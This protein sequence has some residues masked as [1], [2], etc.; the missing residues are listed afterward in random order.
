VGE[1]SIELNNEQK[2]AVEATDK[3]LIVLAGPGSGK[4]R[5][6]IHKLNYIIAKLGVAPENILALTFTNKA[7]SEIRERFEKAANPFTSNKVW[8]S[9]FHSLALNILRSN[10][11]ASGLNENFTL[12]DSGDSKKVIKNLTIRMG[13]DYDKHELKD[14][15]GAISNYKN[16]NYEFDTDEEVIYQ[17]Y[18]RKLKE[19]NSIDFDDILLICLEMLSKEKAIL[20][21]YRAKFQ[22]LLIDEFQ[23]TNYIQHAIVD[24][25]LGYNTQTVLVGDV[26]QSIY[27]WR[28][29]NPEQLKVLMPKARVIRLIGNYRSKSNI[30]NLC[31]KLIQNNY[32]SGREDM[33]SVSGDNGEAVEYHKFIESK[34]ECTVMVDLLNRTTGSKAILIRVNSMSR[35]L[36]EALNLKAIPYTIVGG[37]RF[38]E[39][40]EI[41]DALA[42]IKFAL[43]PFDLLSFERIINTPKRKLGAKTVEKILG[44]SQT[45]SMNL[46]DASTALISKNPEGYNFC[47]G[48]LKLRVLIKDDL[49]KALKYVYNDMGL[50]SYYKKIDEETKS[51]HVEN[52]DSLLNAVREYTTKSS[53]SID[54]IIQEFDD[55]E[56]FALKFIENATLNSVKESS[57]INGIEIMTVHMAKGKEFDTVWVPGLEDSIYPHYLP[58]ESPDEEEER[59]LLF[60][61]CSRAKE[62]LYLSSSYSR[63]KYGEYASN[64]ESP[65]IKE[66][67]NCYTVFDQGQHFGAE[68]WSRPAQKYINLLNHKTL[69]QSE[70]D[71][72]VLGDTLTHQSFG[73]GVV[74]EIDGSTLTIKFSSGPKIINAL[75]APLQI[76]D[77]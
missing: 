8:I 6:I 33:S 76:A 39:R 4:T 1:V 34:D 7:A 35:E 18:Q 36:E 71:N 17:A 16:G 72:L 22:Y 55:G 29:A 28:N 57:E 69:S 63:L 32:L 67:A 56:G 51:T 24:L 27:G 59:R 77:K 61:A 10:V 66:I 70:V 9:T 53:V 73:Q 75:K 47:K 15:S 30:V 42:Y 25:F 62:K 2:L 68:R 50:R 49:N 58:G 74:I 26:D 19:L 13:Y 64:R 44:Y 60:V 52:L 12:L 38:Y 20:G 40:A 46:L 11:K 65:F 41:K 21:R 45:N 48:I 5:V 43:N 31:N 3:L 23:D 54:G 14:L 37:V